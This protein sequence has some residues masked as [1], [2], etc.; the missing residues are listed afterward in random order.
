M[1]G[2][3]DILRFCSLRYGI[4]N[5]L[6]ALCVLFT[7]FPYRGDLIQVPSTFS[8]TFLILLPFYFP[9]RSWGKVH[10]FSQ[11]SVILLTGGLPQCMLGYH[12]P[13]QEHTPPPRSTHPPG[14]DP[15]A[16]S[17]LGDTVNAW[18]VRIL[19]ECNLLGMGLEDRGIDTP[20]SRSKSHWVRFKNTWKVNK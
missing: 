16:Q 19:L 7:P 4:L 10:I 2:V 6:M 9:Q 11:A 20:Q 12:P 5:P 17:M 8:T 3:C 15:P 1:A 18:A 14:A 13:S